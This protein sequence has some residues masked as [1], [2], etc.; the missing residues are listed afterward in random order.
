MTGKIIKTLPDF[1]EQQKLAWKAVNQEDEY[2]QMPTI[3][4][5]LRVLE[6]WNGKI[7]YEIL[8]QQPGIFVVVDKADLIGEIKKNWNKQ[9]NSPIYISCVHY[10]AGVVILTPT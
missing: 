10:K 5:L 6:N 7:C 8:T 1:V 2:A 3:E 9:D 4:D